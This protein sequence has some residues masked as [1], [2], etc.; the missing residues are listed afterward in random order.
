[1]NKRRKQLLSELK[2]IAAHF[3]LSLSKIDIF[4]KTAIALDAANKKLLVMDENDHPYFKTI[5]LH[6]INACAV[7]IDYRSIDAGELHEKQMDEFIEMIQ[8]KISHVDP[9]KSVDISLYDT[10]KN[11]VHEL[12]GLINKATS[13]RDKITGM[14]PSNLQLRA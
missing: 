3:R 7:K 6:N 9:L 2:K 11:T 10:K 4:R 5:D 8:L 1:M 14:I 12:N 13:W